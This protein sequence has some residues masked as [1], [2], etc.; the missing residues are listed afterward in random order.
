[1]GEQ[2]LPGAG[3]R[4]ARTSLRSRRVARR[5]G[6]APPS[7]PTAKATA[8]ASCVRPSA[9]ESPAPTKRR[10]QATATRGVL[11]LSLA[12]GTRLQATGRTPEVAAQGTVSFL[13]AEDKQ[14]TEA[15]GTR[16]GMT[17]CGCSQMSPL[18]LRKQRP[19]ASPDR[20]GRGARSRGFL[21]AGPRTGRRT[22]RGG[23]RRWTA[24]PAGHDC[25]AAERSIP[26]ARAGGMQLR[27]AEMTGET[28]RGGCG[29]ARGK[30]DAADRGN[31]GE[32]SRGAVRSLGLKEGQQTS[33][34]V[35]TVCRASTRPGPRSRRREWPQRSSVG[36]GH[37]ARSGPVGASV[38]GGILPGVWTARGG[39]RAR[40]SHLPGEAAMHILER[41][42]MQHGRA[43]ATGRV[44]WILQDRNGAPW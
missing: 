37:E 32:T 5:P 8:R 10:R 43:E 39:A 25:L 4:G 29:E 26:S 18:Q 16:Q 1:M 3:K 41:L 7:Q 21:A 31:P 38:S 13:A 36:M 35:W 2:R 27:R 14:R 19:L 6:R 12:W 28:P 42:Q 44:L 33:A 40:C 24:I 34:A 23:L 9:K 30:Q 17:R 20:A 15:L 11:A 22:R